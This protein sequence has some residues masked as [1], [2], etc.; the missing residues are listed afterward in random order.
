VAKRWM[1]AF[2][3]LM[4]VS[5]GGSDPVSVP[6][7]IGLT[8]D[9]ARELADDLELE[10]HDASGQDRG[11]WSPSNWT[12]AEQE[13]A[14]GTS[15]E[16]GSTVVVE[17]VNHRDTV[18]EARPEPTDP[19]RTPQPEAI[20]GRS[21]C[22]DP[23]GDPR[24]EDGARP[25]AIPPGQ[26]LRGGTLSIE[27]DVL[28]V[29]WES[30]EEIPADTS[31]PGGLFWGAQLWVNEDT[32]YGIDTFLDDETD[33]WSVHVMDWLANEFREIPNEVIRDGNKLAVSIPLE[34]L[35]N[36]EI[37]FRWYLTT[38]WGETSFFH[39]SC[40]GASG[41]TVPAEEQL[42]FPEY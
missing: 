10:E 20:T 33:S 18:G 16:A 6:H 28:T 19:R 31:E 5:C 39:D 29:I 15:V 35:P 21:V 23:A 2:L 11:V 9:E 8:L 14:A 42:V 3:G 4:L 26:D 25:A 37:P 12:V 32:G 38:E 22:D 17:I 24:G 13:P 36:L 1:F 41:S 34:L 7:L 40:P 27:D 30:T